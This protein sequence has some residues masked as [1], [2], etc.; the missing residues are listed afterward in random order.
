MDY[1]SRLVEREE[2]GTPNILGDVRAGLAFQLRSLLE[3]SQILEHELGLAERALAR[4]VAHPRIRVL[5]PQR[6]ARLPIVSFNVQGLHH[7]LVSTWLDHLFGIQARAGCSCAGPYGHRLLG[8]DATH[9]ARYR[10]L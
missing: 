9:S 8:I 10:R 1:A 3:P 7:E 5:G 4:L 6:G 2:G